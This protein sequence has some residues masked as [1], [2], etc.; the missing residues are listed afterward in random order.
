[1]KLRF[2]ALE[3]CLL[4]LSI[5]M[6]DAAQPHDRIHHMTMDR[7]G[8]KQELIKINERY[9][10]SVKPIFQK[11]CFDCHSSNTRYPWYSNLSGVKQLI[12]TDI[13]EAKDHLDMSQDFPF[14]GHASP[15]ADLKAIDKAIRNSDMPPFRYRLMHPGSRLS[16]QDRNAVSEWVKTSLEVLNRKGE[17]RSPRDSVSIAR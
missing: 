13:R 17:L 4:F 10:K 8:N 7:N 2:S 15:L 6:A 12:Q 1:M 3:Y 5:L 14:S 16:E 11:S 9:L